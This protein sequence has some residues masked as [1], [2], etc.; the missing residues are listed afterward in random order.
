MT[1]RSVNRALLLSVLLVAACDRSDP[2]AP[3]DPADLA[4]AQLMQQ[5]GTEDRVLSQAIP[6][7]GGWFLQDGQPAVYVTDLKQEARARRVLA[8]YAVA[9]GASAEGIL[10]LQARFGFNELEGW[11]NRAW[12]RVME[13]AGAVFSDLDEANNRILFGVEHAAAARAVRGIAARLGVP[14]SAVEVRVVEPIQLAATLRDKVDPKVGG[15]QIHFTQ[16]LCTM[17]FNAA[18]GGTAAFITNSHC[19]ARQ[20]G[21]DNTVYYQPT[22]SVSST[23]IA[24]EV[25]DPAYTRGSPAPCPKSKRCRRSDSARANY[26][27]GIASDLGGIA[28]TNG[29]NLTITGTHNIASEAD[30]SSTPVPVGGTVSKVGRTTGTSTG[31]VTNTCVNTSVSGTNI[32]QLCQTFVSAA[33]GAGDSGSPVFTG[34]GNVT[35]VG[36]LWGGS[37]SGNSF[38]FSPL[39]NVKD[40]L[41]SFSAH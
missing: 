4:A 36:I 7:Y 37:S 35:L 25:A 14:A 31:R 21:V 11:Y 9:H 5:Q 8:D 6:G 40:E 10:V 1:G 16:Y 39:K 34:S 23:A 26:N 18:F 27:A 30:G 32:M 12:P 22:S 19:T 41:G 28:Q 2:Y 33:V 29:S 20:G 24:V 38:V 17:G 13:V 15:L 3:A